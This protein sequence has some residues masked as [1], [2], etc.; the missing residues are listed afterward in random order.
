MIEIALNTHGAEAVGHER[1]KARYD[2]I[3]ERRS[4]LRPVIRVM[5][6]GFR[7]FSDLGQVFA[8]H[9]LSKGSSKLLK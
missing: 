8:R 4:E 6:E 9:G 7:N 1:I 5:F 3:P 2:L